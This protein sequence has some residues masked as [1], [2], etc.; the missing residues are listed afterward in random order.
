MG[1][2]FLGGGLILLILLGHE[3]RS[4]TMFFFAWPSPMSLLFRFREVSM[5]VSLEVWL[6]LGGEVFLRVAVD[7]VEGVSAE[8][9]L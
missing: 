6:S 7:G 1:D 9:F 4:F 2:L 5:D 3:F 8:G